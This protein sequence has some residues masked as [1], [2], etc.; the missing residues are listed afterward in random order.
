MVT[1]VKSICPYCGVGCGLILEVEGNKIIRVRGNPEHP[2]NKGKLC[3]KGAS[4][5]I[6]IYSP[7][8]LLY[9]LKRDGDKFVRIT[10]DEALDEIASKI[11]DII[12]NYGPDSIAIYGGC[13]NT[14]EET[15]IMG[16]LARFLGTNNVDSCARVCHEPSAMALKEMMGIGGSGVSVEEI[17][18]AKVIVIAGES[19][20][21]SH[22]VLVDYLLEAKRRGA[23]IVVIDPRKT[24]TARLA[25]LH[26]QVR[27]GTDI[28]L[29]NAIAN[30]LISNGLYDRD[31]VKARTVGFEDYAKVVSE[32]GLDD[33]EKITGVPR[34]LMI[35]FA[36][37]ISQKP[38][39]FS[40]GLGL[41]EGGG[42]NAVRA[43]LNLALLTGNVGIDGAGPL[44][45][46]GQSNVQGSGDF[47]K[48]NAFPGGLPMNEESALKLRDVWGFTPPT[49]PGK[50]V[51]DALLKDDSIR[52]MIFFNFNPAH[53]MPNKAKVIERL[54][55]LDLLVVVDAFMTDTAK[56][57]HYVLPTAMW[58]EEEGSVVSLDRMV[59]WRFRAVNPPGEAKT[60]LEILSD[61]ASRFNLLVPKDPKIIF[62]EMVRVA[63]WYSRLRLE[64]V[65][66]HSKN[67]RYPAGELVL[68][69][70]RFLTSDG[71]GHFKIVHYKPRGPVDGKFVLITGRVVT[72][73]NTDTLTG[74]DEKLPKLNDVV[75]VNPAD[76]A[77]LGIKDGA[78]VIIESDCGMAEAIAKASNDVAP[79]SLF[80]IN[81]TNIVNYVV[82]DQLDE[83][84]RIPLYK[85]TYVTIKPT[86]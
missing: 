7:D 61:L 17:P 14:L 59:K 30:Y 81:S 36:R 33:V 27:Q 35:E 57:A 12:N 68:Y 55:K 32:Y 46:R 71:L 6:P 23:K 51:T 85:S 21:E 38:V 31:F 20:T 82:C 74:R 15:Y 78:K 2:V 29:F 70:D 49:K 18:R 47:L 83:E 16:K 67:S 58:A 56:L 50:T 4:A 86:Q 24:P 34:E 19:L 1:L 42:V 80:I 76:M 48:P 5:H 25:D 62:E 66:D 3:G 60:T 73:F 9:P 84:S 72:H 79:G 75:Y 65:M 13:Q 40:W 69:K 22:P 26:L 37:L 10:W 41:S 77:R 28:Y 54:K 44:V 63:P 43:Y 53:S 39:I 11:M 45:Y 64:D 52:A 8:R